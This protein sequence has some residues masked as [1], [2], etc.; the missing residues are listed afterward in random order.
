VWHPELVALR[1][2][3]GRPRHPAQIII[4]GNGTFDVENALSCNLP[5]VPAIIV[6]GDGGSTV[7]EEAAA[8]RP[9]LSVV[10][11][12]NDDL[13]GVMRT[14]FAEHGIRRISAVGGRR[15]ATSLID[16]G[17]VQDLCLTTSQKPGGEPNTPYY[18]GTPPP[19]L[20]PIVIKRGT[21]PAH[22]ILFEHSR[23]NP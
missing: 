22:P 10:V 4:S 2:D 3:L 8:R 7:L 9:W 17:L 11:A 6:T 1:A 14:L 13:R 5:E 20:D 18:I 23:L 19:V 15:T 12:R 16:A 21:D